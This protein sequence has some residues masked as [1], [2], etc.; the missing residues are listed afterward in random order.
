MRLKETVRLVVQKTH[1]EMLTHLMT[2]GEQIKM[3]N[4]CP[5]CRYD[6]LREPP[7]NEEGQGSYEICVC[8]GFQFGNDDYPEK[9]PAY[10]MWRTKWVENGCKWFSKKTQPPKHWCADK[11]LNENKS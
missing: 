6:G 2:M 5:V 10:R 11:Q 1:R 9:E 7:Y 3:L 4:I 8:C